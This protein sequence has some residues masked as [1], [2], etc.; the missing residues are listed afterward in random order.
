M[1]T[2]AASSQATTPLV[3]T[4]D[5]SVPG[6][7]PA[8]QFF[9]IPSAV[10]AR[11]DSVYCRADYGGLTSNAEVFLLLFIDIS[12]AISGVYPAP[13]VGST[14]GATEVF[15]TWARGNQEVAQFPAY[16]PQAE[17]GG[18]IPTFGN[19]ALP[20]IVLPANSALAFQVFEDA[21]NGAGTVAME[22]IFIYY[23]PN[24]G[25]VATATTLDILPLLVP[26][27]TG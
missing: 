10:P 2:P 9:T 12:G 17:E 8:Q 7:S 4:F 11:I 26:A 16:Q 5:L 14:A 6:L 24:A 20:D 19:P 23:T 1:T 27:A 18:E 13:P 22:D 21:D 15:L 3:P 25:A